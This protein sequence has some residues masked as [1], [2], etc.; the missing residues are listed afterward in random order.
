[1]LEDKLNLAII[2]VSLV[3]MTFILYFFH[4]LLNRKYLFAFNVLLILLPFTYF[5]SKIIFIPIYR[6][7]SFLIADYTEKISITTLMI[8]IYFIVIKFKTYNKVIYD[9]NTILLSLFIISILLTQLFTHNIKEAIL[10]TIT[11]SVQYLLVFLIIQRIVN[12]FH[13][14]KTV[15]NS[16][17]V[18]LFAN[19]FFRVIVLNQPFL[20]DFTNN[21]EFTRVGFAALGPAVSYAGYIAIILNIMLGLYLIEKK[22]Y[23]L[24]FFL[25]GFIELLGT[26]TRG[27]ILILTFSLLFLILSKKVKLSR[28]IIFLA[29]FT[30]LAIPLI[31]QI[32][33]IRGR[34][35]TSNLLYDSSVLVRFELIINYFKDLNNI[36]IGKGIGNYSIFNIGNNVY[37]PIH[38]A[39]VEILDFAGIFPLVFFS[40]LLI[41][42]ALIAKRNIS[43]DK[44]VAENRLLF[45]TLFICLI[46]WVVFSNTTST[47]ILYYYPFE[48]TIILYIIIALIVRLNNIV[49]YS[50]EKV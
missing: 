9:F 21:F 41:R 1:M 22:N 28:L 18:L 42:I 14:A 2:I 25:L 6:N 47:S 26:F 45:L 33:S 31:I 30:V 37:L 40:I 50:N 49:K 24:F 43:N 48:G 39:F 34:G 20:Q 32:F 44:L 7:N 10:L 4:L 17:V 23:Y 38:N 15:L 3:G 46:Q 35:V 8:V 19:I 36:F 27:G 29:I 12:S 13:D 11:S 5:L 16:I